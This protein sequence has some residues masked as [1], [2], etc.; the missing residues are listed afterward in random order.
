M[1]FEQ[2]RISRNRWWEKVVAWFPLTLVIIFL[3]ILISYFSVRSVWDIAVLAGNYTLEKWA[4][5][6]RLPNILDIEVSETRYKLWLRFFAPKVSGL[7]AGTYEVEADM[8]LSRVISETLESPKYTDLTITILPGWNMYDIDSYLS[9]KK[10]L[11]TWALLLAARDHF[12]TFQEKYDFL[13]WQISLE[14]F[15]YPDTYRILQTADAY[16]ILDRLLTEWDKKIGE[17]YRALG[18]DAYTK[19]ILS[20]IVEREERKSSEKATVAW[21][22]EKR[23]REWIP[24]GAD[25][26]VCYGYAKTQKQ[27]TPAFIGSVIGEKHP[28]NTRNKQGY[29]PTPISSI[30]LDTWTATIHPNPSPYYYY[31]HDT[32]GVIHYAMTLAEHNANKQ[33]YLQ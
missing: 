11:P 17:S 4:T 27:C 29:I 16:M 7:Q 19:L 18:K 1:S 3:A 14:W 9:E 5:L 8:E 6:S 26:T 12:S 20:S 30:S 23:V 2:R 31:L 24:M 10:I 21:V 13:Q 15:L 22:L 33:T 25:A 32:D 28:Y